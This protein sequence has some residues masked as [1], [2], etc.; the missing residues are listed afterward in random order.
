MVVVGQMAL[1]QTTRCSYINDLRD[2]GSAYRSTSGRHGFGYSGIVIDYFGAVMR[3]ALYLNALRDVV[4]ACCDVTGQK[5]G[6]LR[7]T[8]TFHRRGRSKFRY[9]LKGGASRE[10]CR[11]LVRW[12]TSVSLRA[13][14]LPMPAEIREGETGRTVMEAQYLLGRMIQEPPVIDGDFDLTT[15][16]AV[17]HYQQMFGLPVTGV[18]GNETWSSLLSV[19]PIPPKLKVGS[20]GPVVRRVQRALNE[21]TPGPPF[22]FLV[23]DGMFGPKTEAVVKELQTGRGVVADGIIDLTTWGA[24]LGLANVRFATIVGL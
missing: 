23:E 15:K 19:I 4:G 10:I 14:E 24:A 5:H 16:T 9:K 11:Q 21:L 8:D 13:K 18:V 6:F 17:E 1:T 3:E 22:D 7:S 12:E 20:E 2:F